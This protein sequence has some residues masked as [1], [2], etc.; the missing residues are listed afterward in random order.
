MYLAMEELKFIIRCNV[1]ED[2]A[3]SVCVCVCVC[4]CVWYDPEGNNNSDTGKKF[5]SVYGDLFHKPC[6]HKHCC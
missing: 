3:S 4:L 5:I 6:L 2:G 1:E